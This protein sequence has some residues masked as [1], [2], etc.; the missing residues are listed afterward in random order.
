MRYTATISFE[1]NAESDVQAY[2]RINR[3]IQKTE[4]KY[5]NHPC[6]ISLEEKP[7]GSIVTREIDL[8]TLKADLSAKNKIKEIE[9]IN[10]S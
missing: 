5:D 2:R 3:M 9:L 4:Y 8:E 1:I 6:I 10:N 7:F